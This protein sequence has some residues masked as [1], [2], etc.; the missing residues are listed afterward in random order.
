MTG[1]TAAQG[2]HNAAEVAESSTT[3]DTLPP[4]RPHLLQQGHTS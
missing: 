4:S 3:S 1:S 2:R